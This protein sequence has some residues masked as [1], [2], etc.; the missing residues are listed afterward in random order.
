MLGTA[1]IDP[2]LEIDRPAE[3]G[4]KR[5]ISGG[6]VTHARLRVT[7][8]IPARQTSGPGLL[9]P[10]TL[11]LRDPKHARVCGVVILHHPGLGTGKT[12]A[13]T[14][15]LGGDFRRHRDRRDERKR[16]PEQPPHSMVIRRLSV[17]VRPSSSVQVK[18]SSPVSVA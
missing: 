4:V 7:M 8:T 17:C 11:A 10:Q 12:I 2:L 1:E 14:P 6:H 9:G 13:G 5:R 3:C 15:C 18:T 16:Y